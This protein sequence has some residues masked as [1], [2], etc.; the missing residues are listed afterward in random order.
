MLLED[1]L[2]PLGLSQV[3]LAEL[4]GVHYPRVNEIINGKRGIS[5]DTAL[6]LGRLLGTTPEFWLNGQLEYDLHRAMNSAA[7]DE[8]RK[9]RPLRKGVA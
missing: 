6:R 7:A 9:I 3:K 4:I 1:F 8:I 5:V 2:K